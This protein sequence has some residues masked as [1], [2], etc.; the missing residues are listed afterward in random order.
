MKLTELQ[1][2]RRARLDALTGPTAAGA[3]DPARVKAAEDLFDAA[4]AVSAPAP[5]AT[6]SYVGAARR[7]WDA[8]G[9]EGMPAL[10]RAV[11]AEG[12][13]AHR[14]RLLAASK[15]ELT[16]VVDQLALLC[17]DAEGGAAALARLLDLKA[18]LSAGQ[19]V[20]KAH[21]RHHKTS[22][23]HQRSAA[24][25]DPRWTEVLAVLHERLDDV[26]RA[27]RLVTAAEHL[28][29]ASTR[30]SRWARLAHLDV[31]AV[32][33]GAAVGTV[34]AA[35]GKLVD[36][37]RAA[38]GRDDGAPRPPGWIKRALAKAKAVLARALPAPVRKAA[39]TVS[40][41][42]KGLI[43]ALAKVES[44]PRPEVL[45]DRFID[46]LDAARPLVDPQADAVALGV[47][48]EAAAVLVNGAHGHELLYN[49]RTG[50]LQVNALDSVGLR[51]GIGATVRAFCRN[52]YGDGEAI[53]RS[54]GRAGLEVGALFGQAGFFTL[55]VPGVSP[56]E[57]P[58]GWSANV[59]LG[60]TLSVIGLGDQSMFTLRERPT[61]TV[62]LTPAQR[63]RIEAVLA[64]IPESAAT[65]T[66]ALGEA[67]KSA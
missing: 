57:A 56:E 6:E 42:A 61:V 8:R 37:A 16:A 19:D 64:D 43:T 35:G 60:Y 65:Y 34:H 41:G 2:A 48:T 21:R 66:D 11:A 67:V 47:L 25:L 23:A 22:L 33:A 20:A 45:V 36:A 55:D 7:L 39:D 30:I 46:A 26:A 17:L 4:G 62:D 49:R 18:I 12:V 31:A 24:P 15:D 9:V 14:A 52:L 29:K 59:S 5:R 28:G 58:R 27:E 13:G 10:A 63:A 44:D 53:A 1:A 3:P 51:L 32:A 50:Q 54:R 40:L 38:F